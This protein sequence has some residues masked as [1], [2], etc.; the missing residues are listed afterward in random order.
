MKE[1]YLPAGSDWYD[2]WTGEKI[3]YDDFTGV[4]PLTPDLLEVLTYNAGVTSNDAPF[5]TNFPY[6]ASPWPGTHNCICNDSNTT[7]N[8]PQMAGS[9]PTTM[10]PAPKLGLASPEINLTAYPNPSKGSTTIKYSVDAPSQIKLVAYDIN[11]KLIK[12]LTDK[13]HEA[14]VYVLTWDNGDLAPGTYMVT[15]LKNGIAKKVIKLVRN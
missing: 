14:G 11:G 7:S 5:K 2:F 12:V 15:A 3:W 9:I 10:A 1:T 13:K 6:V 8:N 4:N